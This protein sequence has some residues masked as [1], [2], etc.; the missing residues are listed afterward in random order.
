MSIDIDARIFADKV[1]ERIERFYG[2][3]IIFGFW[4]VIVQG[5]F[6]KGLAETFIPHLCIEDAETLGNPTDVPFVQP[7]QFK[8]GESDDNGKQNHDSRLCADF[9]IFEPSNH[10][11]TPFP[12]QS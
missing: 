4:D 2:I 6:G 5:F 10:S 11:G 3:G 7:K 12:R 1:E 8:Q 9:Q